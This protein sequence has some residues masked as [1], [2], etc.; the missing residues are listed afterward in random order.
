[1]SP[2]W[3]EKQAMNREMLKKNKPRKFRNVPTRYNGVRYDSI[4]EADY[5]A[6]LDIWMIGE[7]ILGWLRQVTFQLG[8]DFK[9]RVDFLVIDNDMRC[10]AHEVK[11]H[12]TKQFKTVRRLW[13]KYAP[14]N[15]VIA[16]RHRTGVWRCE[17]IAGKPSKEVE[18][19]EQRK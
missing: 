3:E 19:H 10:V 4:A 15:L 13:P 7:H 8:P 1:M 11:G 5:A 18:N 16:K 9:A 6:L 14:C 17:E 2:T 12:E